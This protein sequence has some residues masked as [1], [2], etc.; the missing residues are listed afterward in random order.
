[1]AERGS[2]L[3]SPPDDT[4]RAHCR[5]AAAPPRGREKP[6]RKNGPALLQTAHNKAVC[7]AAKR[8][9]EGEPG[10]TCFFLC[11]R[12]RRRA[13]VFSP[14]AARE[15]SSGRRCRRSDLN[16]FLSLGKQRV[17]GWPFFVLARKG[18]ECVGACLLDSSEISHSSPLE[19]RRVN[20]SRKISDSSQPAASA[21][22]CTDSLPVHV[23][24]CASAFRFLKHGVGDGALESPQRL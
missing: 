4:G 11:M 18:S 22:A 23:V 21:A 19:A 5:R 8:P 12:P 20:L 3:D 7:L 15:R 6:R 24:S 16:T 1:M 9:V 13:C 14:R 2:T 10:D 17:E